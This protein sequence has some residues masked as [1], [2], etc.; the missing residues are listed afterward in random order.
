MTL[1]RLTAV[2][3]GVSPAGTPLGE[4]RPNN[5]EFFETHYL[6]PGMVRRGREFEAIAPLL[7]LQ[8]G[9]RGCR[10]DE[11]HPDGWALAERYGIVFD[12]DSLPVFLNSL[13][14]RISAD[15]IPE[16]VFVVTDSNSAYQHALDRMPSSIRTVRLYEDYLTNFTINTSGGPR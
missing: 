14:A 10:I 11:I 15:D 8:A 2:A 7:W 1:P 4:A 16:A 9:G 13:R 5:V 3:T 6:D 12:V